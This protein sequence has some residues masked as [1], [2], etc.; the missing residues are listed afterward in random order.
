MFDE[1]ITAVPRAPDMLEP[2]ELFLGNW[3]PAQ[4]LT[5]K[6]PAAEEFHT[7]LRAIDRQG[8]AG[9]YAAVRDSDLR[10]TIA[11]IPR[12]T[13]V[14]AGQHDTV[15]AASLGEL[16]AATVPGAKLLVLPAPSLVERGVPCRVHGGGTRLSTLSS[17]PK[18]FLYVAIRF[19]CSGR[20]WCVRN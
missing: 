12:P 17:I 14:I 3:F 20:P 13:L 5:A 2:A 15:T 1:R 7:M 16:T 19:A 4:M 8:L 6:E 11:L 18:K 9:L 10:R